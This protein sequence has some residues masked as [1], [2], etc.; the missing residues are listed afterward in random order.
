[1]QENSYNADQTHFQ[2]YE[3]IDGV[4]YIETVFFVYRERFGHHP[5]WLPLDEERGKREGFPTQ[6]HFLL[7]DNL[8]REEAI[9]KVKEYRKQ[10]DTIITDIE[11][12]DRKWDEYP[13]QNRP[14]T[15]SK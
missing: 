13:W 6:F 2:Y 10:Y 7:D 3:D 8:T 12:D 15:F 1:M 5:S 14:I 4:C 11:N 9:A